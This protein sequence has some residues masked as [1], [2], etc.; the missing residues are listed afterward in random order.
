MSDEKKEKIVKLRMTVKQFEI[1]H[2][3]AIEYGFSSVCEYIRFGLFLEKPIADKIK[4]IYEKVCPNE[5][6]SQT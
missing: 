5:Q 2:Q 3:K 4:S 1:L 6:V